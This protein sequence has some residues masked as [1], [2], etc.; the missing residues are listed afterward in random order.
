MWDAQ[1]WVNTIRVCVGRGM[2]AYRPATE[3]SPRAV[4]VYQVN[5]VG[6]P[7]EAIYLAYW[8]GH[9]WHRAHVGK[10]LPLV[11]HSAYGKLIYPVSHTQEAFLSTL[12]VMPDHFKEE[13]WWR[14]YL[15]DTDPL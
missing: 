3:E 14:G 1:T 2:S 13:I 10:A 7:L 8:D 9:N 6:Y 11:Q 15:F 12:P 4:G 5:F